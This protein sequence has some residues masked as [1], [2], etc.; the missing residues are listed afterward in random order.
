MV[1]I[2]FLNCRNYVDCSFK[3]LTSLTNIQGEQSKFGNPFQY[4]YYLINE[5]WYML[6]L[7]F[8]TSI[9]LPY[10]QI[11]HGTKNLYTSDQISAL[12]N[13]EIHNLH[14]TKPY[15]V[16]TETIYHVI[17]WIKETGK[18]SSKTIHYIRCSVGLRINSQ[19]VNSHM[20]LNFWKKVTETVKNLKMAP[21]SLNK[22]LKEGLL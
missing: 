18:T 6:S 3:I 14:V 19:M 1:C 15:E 22:I 11:P 21:K 20:G 2:T 16:H 10:S 17:K 5:T 9:G 12:K 13:P 8:D 7:S 4:C